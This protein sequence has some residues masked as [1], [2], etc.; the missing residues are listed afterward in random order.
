MENIFA[1]FTRN[2][3]LGIRDILVRVRIHTYELW[4]T[5]PDPYP[6]LFFSDFKDIKKNFHIF[7]FLQLTPRHIIF[8]L[9]I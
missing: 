6:T 7:F 3:V 2:Q 5:D 9:K 8:S 4:V 1:K